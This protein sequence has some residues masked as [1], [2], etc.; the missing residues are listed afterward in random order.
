MKEEVNVDV[1]D[2][3]FSPLYINP[4]C[5]S[6]VISFECNLSHLS[7]GIILD[8]LLVPRKNSNKPGRDWKYNVVCVFRLNPPVQSARRSDFVASK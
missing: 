3:G 8:T 4:I 6:Y 7:C 5:P 2:A 1:V